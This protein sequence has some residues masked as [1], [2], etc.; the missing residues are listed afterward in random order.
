MA[1]VEGFEPSSD[2]FGDRSFTVKLHPYSDR[3]SSLGGYPLGRT[4]Q[5]PS[6]GK[7]LQAQTLE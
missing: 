4:H 5:P 1:W 7:V 6:A 3:A 2:G